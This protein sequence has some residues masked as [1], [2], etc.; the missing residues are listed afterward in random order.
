MLLIPHHPSSFKSSPSPPLTAAAGE[1][2]PPSPFH[3]FAVDVPSRCHNNGLPLTI[4]FSSPFISSLHVLHP[5]PSSA[6]LY[7]STSTTLCHCLLHV[8]VVGKLPIVVLH[9]LPPLVGV[10]IL[11]SIFCGVG[12][13]C[14]FKLFIILLL[15]HHIVLLWVASFLVVAM[16]GLKIRFPS[17]PLQPQ[18]DLPAAEDHTNV[19]QSEAAEPSTTTQPTTAP[20]SKKRVAQSA[21]APKQIRALVWKSK[22]VLHPD[23]EPIPS[24][25]EFDKPEH[26][27]RCHTIRS[28]GIDQCKY[29]VPHTLDSL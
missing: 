17:P 8:L 29:L 20:S 21:E 9:P 28:L 25:L 4:T 13:H 12:F 23:P 24:G 15:I 11:I 14:Q 7:S 16:T 22:S 5:P 18:D 19:H 3:L 6:Y 2:T 10:L 27:S 26:Q 1:N